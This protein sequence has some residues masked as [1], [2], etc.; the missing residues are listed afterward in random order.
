MFEVKIP[1]TFL[2]GVNPHLTLKLREVKLLSQSH[3]VEPV[4]WRLNPFLGTYLVRESLAWLG[5][6]HR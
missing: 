6:V 3:T 4:E 1:I 5:S 2:H